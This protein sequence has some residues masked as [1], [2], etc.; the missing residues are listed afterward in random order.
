MKSRAEER[1]DLLTGIGLLVDPIR[2]LVFADDDPLPCIPYVRSQFHQDLE[3]FRIEV[4]LYCRPGKFRFETE[5]DVILRET[6]RFTD[7]L[8][9]I[10]YPENVEHSRQQ[11][12]QQMKKVQDAIRAVPCDDPGIILPSESPYTTYL[13]LGA[14]CRDATGRLQLFD[15]YLEANTFHRYLPTIADGVHVVIVT[16]SDIMDL[17]ATAS[18]TSNKTIRRDRIVSISELLAFQFPDGYQFRVSSELHDR[19]IRVDDTILHLGGSA[20]D[21]GRS[22]YFTISK[23]DPIQSTHAFLDGIIARASEWYGPSVRPH[24]RT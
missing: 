20:K 13:H 12:P 10:Q 8:G 9:S 22:A 15:P 19:H 3:R 18:P 4:I 23:L 16:S 14:I 24:R 21:A 7:F 17:P 5:M 11:F 2:R 6:R 1:D